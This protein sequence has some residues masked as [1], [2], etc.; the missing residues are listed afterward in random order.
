MFTDLIAMGKGIMSVIT[1]IENSF[2]HDKSL[3]NSYLC[4]LQTDINV[5]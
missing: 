3:N 2:V 5:K 1:S 4:M